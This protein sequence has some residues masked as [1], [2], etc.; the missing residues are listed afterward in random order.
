[1]S[2]ELMFQCQNAYESVGEWNNEV[3]VWSEMR[4]KGIRKDLGC[5]WV[6][7]MD[8]V[9]VFYAREVAQCARGAEVV[10]LLR[11]L[12]MR[13][14]ERG[15]VDETEKGMED[16]VGIH[17]ERL[18][19]GFGLVSVPKGMTIRVIKNLRMCR[20]RHERFKMISN[21]VGRDF[22]VRDLNRFHHFKVGETEM[23][24]TEMLEFIKRIAGELIQSLDETSGTSYKAEQYVNVYKAL[25]DG[26][27]RH[28]E[29]YEIFDQCLSD[30]IKG[31]I[32]RKRQG[33]LVDWG[34]LKDGIE[35][36]RTI[37]PNA[38]IISMCMQ[39]YTDGFEKPLFADASSYY[40]Q[41]APDHI[42]TYSCPEYMFMVEQWLK[43]E[44][45][46]AASSLP[47][48]SH[49]RLMAVARHEL[50]VAHHK[51]LL[52]K[53]HSGLKV[54]LQHGKVEDLKRMYELFSHTKGGLGLISSVFVKF[55][56]ENGIALIEQAKEVVGEKKV[57][58]EGI[59]QLY[60]EFAAYISYY[61][62]DNSV[63]YK[64]L[65]EAFEVLCN[66]DKCSMT[67]AEILSRFDH[68]ILKKGSGSDKLSDP[69][70]KEKLEKMSKL[71]SYIHEK[72]LFVEFHR[73]NLAL[74]FLHDKNSNMEHERYFAL[75]LKTQNDDRLTSKIEGMINDFSLTRERRIYFKNFLKKHR[76]EKTDDHSFDMVVRVLTAGLWPSLDSSAL[77]L[78]PELAHGVEV[79]KEFYNSQNKKK[80]LTWSHSLGTC[81]L[82]GHFDHKP[83]E[84]MLTTH[85]ASAL[86]LFNDSETL[87]FN[88]IKMQ[89]N[90]LENDLI[91]VL[92]SLSCSKYKILNK[93]PNSKNVCSKD[94]FKFNSE[95]TNTEQR[96]KV[97]LP[98]IN[99]NEGITRKTQ[100]DRRY[101]I[102]AAIVRIM[103]NKKETE[104]K[105]IEVLEFIKRI[106]GELIQ[107]LD[108]TSGTSYKVEQYVNVY[109]AVY[110]ALNK[111]GLCHEELYEI[112]DQCLSDYIKG[113]IIPFLMD[114]DSVHL[115][116]KF[117]KKWSIYSSVSTKLSHAFDS[118]ER[119]DKGCIPLQ[120]SAKLLFYILINQARE[121]KLVDW[122]SLNYGIEL[123]RTVQSFATILGH[124]CMQ[125]YTDGFEKPLFADASSYYSQIAADHIKTCSCP[126]YMFMVEQ[127]LKKEDKIAASSLP[128]I[129]H[130]GLIAVARHEL[131]IVHHKQLLEKEHS[132]LKV[133]LQHGK[134]EDLKRMYE[135]FSH[136]KGGLGLISSV[137]VKFFTEN[138]IALIEQ[139]KEAVGEKKVF[140][141]GILQL[142]DEFA[143]YITNYFND[144]TAF[145]KA[146]AEAFEVLCN[147][148]KCGMT[149]AEML[150]RLVH[151]I[152][153]KGSGSDKRSDPAIKEK[154]KK[155][156]KL[157]SYIHE[158]DLFVEFHRKNLALRLLHDKNSNMELERY[159]ALKLK[160]R[161]DDQL[162]SKI[163]GMINDFSLT[164]EIQID[165]KNL[166]KHRHEK[167]DDHSV[168]MVVR[169]LTAGLW[170]SLNSSALHLPPELAHGV[171]VF[172]QIYVTQNKKKRL[173]WSHSLGT[174]ILIGHFD[175][176]PIELMLTT[177]Q[178]SALML[179]N[180]SETLSFNDIKTQLNLQ[181]NDLIGVMHSLSCSKYK[182]LNKEPNSK[183]VSRNDIFKFNTEFTNTTQ[184]IKVP[185]PS[186]THKEEMTRK[187]RIDRRYAIEA[188]IVRIMKNRKPDVRMIEMQIDV[189]IQRDYLKRDPKQRDTLIYLP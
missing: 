68:N 129:S 119:T 144:N 49:K 109:D 126:E 41:I 100:I 183:N 94:I 169:V 34:S 154:L 58:P 115:L 71:V 187:K 5:S 184:R 174:C 130:K 40:S 87:S 8:M 10:E 157:V 36:F 21:I 128:L 43:K 47:L 80:K 7:I 124:K 23:K 98:P 90:L 33:K 84:F 149:T 24:P 125:R 121:G 73:K 64:A 172:N 170:P 152:L 78:P 12:E 63:F 178:A 107:S 15:Y 85:Q 6:E 145:Y 75:K 29:L 59:L 50:L 38:T 57:F 117:S 60:D 173:T 32:N 56:T 9:Y 25:Y 81:V 189:L 108:E 147:K 37:Q 26:D 17:S 102:D 19:L 151:N 91:G 82:I 113:V 16:M 135:L 11:E 44:D 177:Y 123:F 156:S 22:V 61:F 95:F 160:T 45:E 53:E 175:Q 65:A 111:R 140:P 27:L 103:K 106:A 1:M 52:E 167:S 99:H 142:Y 176:K 143:V 35:L 146:L 14:E 79:F 181:E 89:L 46:I 118:L 186:I 105:P 137:F 163:E 168:D 39:R 114:D 83:I 77:R 110:D 158:K 161:N 96:I 133:L 86:M 70:I 116:E 54:L 153:K 18:A 28:E 150:S 88:D 127:C 74:R 51:Q 166:E 66:E 171:E 138:G 188:A 112:F 131:L 136:T 155:M 185:L 165:F 164:K 182:I 13:M 93:E 180:D 30:Y 31:V 55:F 134:V 67:T 122:G 20:D 62:N 104:M 4:R 179:F 97:P 92:H 162:T 132:G 48:I 120:E 148:D 141:E 3:K 76:H 69:A 139:A 2:Q 101:A 159:F 42:K 72:D